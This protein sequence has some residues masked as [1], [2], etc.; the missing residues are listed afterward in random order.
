MIE[1]I[2]LEIAKKKFCDSIEDIHKSESQGK[3]HPTLRK[4]DEIKKVA[5]A[6]K[7]SG[8]VSSEISSCI[9][10]QFKDLINEGKLSSESIEKALG[11][12]IKNHNLA[13]NGMKVVQVSGHLTSGNTASGVGYVTVSGG[14]IAS[15][16]GSNIAIIQSDSSGLGGL[17]VTEVSGVK[18]LSGSTEAL[19]SDSENFTNSSSVDPSGSNENHA[20][21]EPHSTT[22][23][24]QVIPGT[25]ILEFG[26]TTTRIS[27]HVIIAEGATFPLTGKNEAVVNEPQLQ[28]SSGLTRAS[29]AN[30]LP[31][32]RDNHEF[33]RESIAAMHDLLEPVGIFL[34]EQI[35]SLLPPIDE[36][37]R[38]IG[39][40]S[41]PPP[42][43][44]SAISGLTNSSTSKS[45]IFFDCLK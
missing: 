38:S 16:H 4:N 36:F 25:P 39:L 23:I 22:P 9:K 34:A 17:E 42:N 10:S 15:G 11:P 8:M 19:N 43:R 29:G 40:R 24:I 14:V 1:S 37:L 30:L 13:R 20:A 5:N 35:P 21:Q 28:C 7:A 41:S 12:E 32:R 44:F 18:L 2:A 45:G 6:Y 3:K 26:A 27:G 33:D 31:E